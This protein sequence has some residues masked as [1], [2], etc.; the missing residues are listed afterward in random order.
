MPFALD[1][2]QQYASATE[3]FWYWMSVIV[4]F[5][6]IWRWLRWEWKIE[7]MISL[8]NAW[9]AI[10]LMCAAF[11]VWVNSVVALLYSMYIL[12]ILTKDFFK[13]MA[14]TPVIKKKAKKV[15]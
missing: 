9:F 7:G 14:E 3:V 13:W 5:C 6:F 12:M 11:T 1:Y 8:L 15:L 4:S 10:G 2:L